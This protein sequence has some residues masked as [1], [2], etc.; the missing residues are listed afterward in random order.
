[1][2]GLTDDP[3][4]KD[5]DGHKK[6]CSRYVQLSRLETETGLYLLQ[7]LDMNDL[8]FRPHDLLLAEMERL[9]E[10]ERKTIVTYLYHL[11]VCVASFDD[12]IGTDVYCY[13]FLNLETRESYAIMFHH[14]FKVL[15]EVGRCPVRFPHI[16][17]GRHPNDHCRHVQEA[18][19]W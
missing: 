19:T 3:T 18:S 14:I 17:G 15:G 7:E 13:A 5:Q 10:L 2:L 12:L 16:H 11:S 8:R 9:R 1:V 4:A 6:F